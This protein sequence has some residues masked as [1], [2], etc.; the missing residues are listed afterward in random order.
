M[1]GLVFDIKHFS[2]HDGPGIRT[3]IFLKGCPLRCV[4]CQNPEGLDDNRKIIYRKNRCE[5][6]H[7]CLKIA[8]DNLKLVDGYIKITNQNFDNWDKVI[9]NCPT[10]SIE[11][12]SNYYSVDELMKVIH[13]D[14]PFYRENGGV[15]ISGGEPLHQYDFLLELL[16]RCK[17]ENINTCIETSGLIDEEKFTNLLYFLDNIYMDFKLFDDN[18]HFN[19]TKVH[20]DIIKNNLQI[21]LNSPLKDVATIRTPLIPNVTTS[22][23]NI[24]KIANY[25]SKI[26]NNTNYELLNFNPLSVPKYE[27]TEKK[28]YFKVNPSRFTEKEMDNFRN[29]ARKYLKNII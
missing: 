23:N 2:V 16:K 11:Y 19:Y 1:K 14:L 27:L 9:N 24:E 17:E 25:L 13:K 7:E 3:T 18:D 26:N 15:T 21:L 6:F 4:W 10:N 20:N 5:Q 8:P 28:Y 29:Y 12:D 22:K